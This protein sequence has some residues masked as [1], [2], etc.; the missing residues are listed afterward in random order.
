MLALTT[1][2]VGVECRQSHRREVLDRIVGEVA[3]KR[4][5]DRDRA[6]CREEQRV[7]VG[8]GLRDVLGRDRAVRARPVLDDDGLAKQSPQ[9]L[10]QEARDEIGSAAG[11]E[12]HHEPDRATRI[13]LRL[14]ALRSRSHERNGQCA[15]PAAADDVP[16]HAAEHIEA[17]CGRQV[18][19]LDPPDGGR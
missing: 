18:R 17:R 16:D 12:G 5:I 4:R 9:T 3:A 19:V 13:L 1:S 2:M 6:Y 11:G 15:E 8:I 7:A 10:G 14:R